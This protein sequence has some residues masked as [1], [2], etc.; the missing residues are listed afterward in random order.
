MKRQILLLTILSLICQY[1]ISQE[2]DID[3]KRNLIK[4]SIATSGLY[5]GMISIDYERNIVF[6]EKVKLNIE[7][8]FGKYYQLHTSDSYQSHPS[9]PSFTTSLNS[10]IGKKSHFLEIDLGARYSIINPDYYNDINHLF[11]VINI[12][13]RYQNY[14]KNGLIFKVFLG[15]TGFGLSTGIAF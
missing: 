12:G 8:T 10:L 14:S 3:V 4:G 5:N 2:T 11:P 7:G 6:A 15:T 1:S 9:F 13:Y